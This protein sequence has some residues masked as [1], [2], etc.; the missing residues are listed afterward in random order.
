MEPLLAVVFVLGL[1][2]WLTVE[3][4]LV[5]MRSTRPAVLLVNQHVADGHPSV[6][7]TYADSTVAV[8]TIDTARIGNR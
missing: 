4:I 5:L 1:P 8:T 7:Y 2:V 3:Q 6:S